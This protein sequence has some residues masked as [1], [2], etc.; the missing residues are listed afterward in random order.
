M[1]IAILLPY[2]EDYSPKYAGAVSIHVS[3]LQKYS[4][5]KNSTIVYGN[6]NKKK[7]LSSNFKNIKV[8]SSILFSNNKKYLEKFV[9]LNS[10]YNPD[11]VEIHNRPS[12][13]NIIKNNLKSKIILYFHNNPLTIS[14]SRS[15]SDRIKLL[16][17]CEF[18][19]FNSKWT[20]N[21]F[22]KD[23]NSENYKSKFGVC[24]QSTKK[25]KINIKKKEKI[26][27]FVGKLNSAKGY[28]VFGQAV[29]KILNE[30]PD[31]KSVVVGD[32]PREKLIF[33]HKNL[34]IYNFK[35]NSFV[36]NLLKKTSI[37]V[38]CSRWEEPFGRSSLEASSLAC[39]TIITNKGGL[40]ETTRH[41]II[42]RKLDANILYNQI[43]KLI[44]NTKLRRKFQILNYK[45]FFL[46]HEFVSKI[47]DKVRTN[48][49]E[50]LQVKKFNV[51]NNSK[52]KIIHVT[53][54]NQRYFGRLQY[55]TGIRLNN[56][57]IR[58]GHNVI[59]LSDR[60]IINYSKSFKDPTGSKYLNNLI[61]ETIHNFKPD[62]LI[63]GHADKISNETLL[64]AKSKYRHLT[65]AQWFLDPLS[66][67][68]PDYQKNK[69]RILDKIKSMDATFT[70]T[71]PGSLDFKINNS[72]FI[73][74]PCDKSLDNLKNFNHQPKNDVFYAISHGVHRGVL[75]SGKIDERETFI[76]NLRKKCKNIKFDTYGMFGKQ[77]IWGQSFLK[78]LSNSKMGLNLSRGKPIKYYSSDRLA[79]LMGNGLLTFIDQKTCYSDFF[80]NDEMIFYKNLEDLTEKIH[81]FKKDD[82][83]RKKI[84]QRGNTKYHKYFN[85]DLVAKYIILKS[86]GLK[87]NFY[88][89]S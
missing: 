36:L 72:F 54:F 61:F 51:S 7:F 3:N 5:F 15:K 10:E 32:E 56:G 66:R 52:L 1:N 43:K 59:S 63:L 33:L 75:R 71:D 84:A 85:S 8:N 62:L 78:E 64:E 86:M 55:N 83:L 42:I 28:D 49:L 81:K 30:F 41:P 77:P 24:F 87:T 34:K 11:I 25:I 46:T 50:N 88:W 47:I 22:F 2:K 9:E 58:L 27:S 39:A 73:P 20:Q 68:G 31:W 19:F 17:E 21:Q 44:K 65:I 82:K 67:K 16:D 29:V 89:E 53:N 4:K 26:I 48:I 57:L 12:Y 40:S 38:A 74:N 60:D 23:I 13:V 18:I 79:Q 69:I 6:T 37:F 35:E 76:R 80:N 14:G 45:S 70:T